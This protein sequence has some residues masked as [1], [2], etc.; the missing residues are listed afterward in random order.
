MTAGS[1]GQRWVMRR[2][3]SCRLTLLGSPTSLDPPLYPSTLP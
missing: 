3:V 1:T 2:A